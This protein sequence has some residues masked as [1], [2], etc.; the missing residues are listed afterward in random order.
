[1]QVVGLLRVSQGPCIEVVLRANI[2]VPDVRVTPDTLDFGPVLLGQEKTMYY[3]LHNVTPVPV[4]WAS[5]VPPPLPHSGASKKPRERDSFRSEPAG[6]TLAPGERC[7]VAVTFAPAELRS[8]AVPLGL[9][10]AQN[11]KQRF[12][13]TRGTG[14]DVLLTFGLPKA[15]PQQLLAAASSATVSA[16]GGQQH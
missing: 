11:T 5:V 10:L 9:R 14:S 4:Q 1:M 6:G 7:A 16:S 2:T 15:P 12:V 13:G 3:Q 8:Y